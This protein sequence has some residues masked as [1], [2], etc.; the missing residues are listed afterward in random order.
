MNDIPIVSFSER[1][2]M[3]HN[4]ADKIESNDPVVD[5]VMEAL[6]NGGTVEVDGKIMGLV[7]VGE[8]TE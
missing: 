1:K 7:E 2:N 5:T 4:A 8:E 6:L 3:A